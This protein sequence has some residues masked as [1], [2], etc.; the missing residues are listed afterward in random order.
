MAEQEHDQH[1][2]DKDRYFNDPDYR[3]KVQKFREWELWFRRVLIIVSLLIVVPIV[4]LLSFS[5]TDLPSL[6]EL[7]NPR[8]ELA[9][10]VYSYDGEVIHRFFNTNRRRITLAEMSPHVVNALLASEDRRFYDH[11]GFDVVRFF[12]AMYVNLSTLSF[13][14][15]AS[16]ITQQLSRTLFLKS[17]EQT[18]TR[19]IREL[20]TAIHIEVTY[21]KNEI[22]EMYLNQVYFGSGAYG[23]QAAAQTYFNKNARDLTVLEAA[24]LIGALPAPN[25]F[26]P[27]N[28]PEKSQERRNLILL[29][30]VDAGYLT[31]DDYRKLKTEP[32]LTDFRPITDLGQAPYFTEQVRQY[33]QNEGEGRGFNLYND[34]LSVFTTIDT[35]MQTIADQVVKG[36]LDSIQVHF[37][38]TMVWE[39][40]LMR[41]LIK[42]TTPYMNATQIRGEDTTR[43][44]NR[45]KKNKA[46]IDSLKAAK[47]VLQAGFVVMD[48]RTG[49]VKA[50]VGGRDFNT[51]KFDHV[52]LARRQPGSSFKPIIYSVVIDK[53]YPPTYE[54]LN[55]PITIEDETVKGGWWTP[56]NSEGEF[57]GMTTLREALRKSLN[58]ITIRL[59]LDI[60]KPSEVVQVARRMGITSKL[61]AVNSIALGSSEVTVMELTSAYSTFP[62]E[63][64]HAEPLMVMRVEDINGNILLENSPQNQEVF[65]KETAYIV[66]NMLQTVINRGT[67]AGIRARFGFFQP[68]GGKTG[69]TNDHGDA[70]FVG[71][72]SDLVAGVWVGFSD[73]RIHFQTMEHG[74]GARAAMPIWAKFMKDV[75]D[76]RDIGMPSSTFRKPNGIYEMMVCS[77]S[78]KIAGSFCPEPY[79]EVF[80]KLNAPTETCTVHT[81][82]GTVKPE[83]KPKKK[84]I[85]F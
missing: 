18:I 55:Q 5:L 69:T 49:M 36:H 6:E 39:D 9:T 52:A 53:G 78:K 63:G 51:V 43:V 15:G 25:T 48:P 84:K 35:R 68:A 40:D 34:G 58:L 7:E 54:V 62:N 42:E 38:Q 61:W 81:E 17:Q 71:Y 50:Y 41:V 16:T 73:R 75:Y 13:S 77:E 14:E 47:S 19:K 83:E 26:N 66:N 1:G 32:T 10:N 29:N 45:L 27:V 37:N 76:N 21:T 64:L 31:A 70:W 23:I 82:A 46:F 30:M 72:T 85:G 4:L 22:L 8:Q 11:W 44:M 24:A 20:Y 33:L 80:T 2:L 28:R 65:S 59:V 57:G 67:G 74:Q 79:Q 60:A 3:R 56:K 12:K